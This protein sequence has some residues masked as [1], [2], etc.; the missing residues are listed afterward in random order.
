MGPDHEKSIL[1]TLVGCA[2][3]IVILMLASCSGINTPT[4][5]LTPLPGTGTPSVTQEPNSCKPM[6][7]ATSNGIALLNLPDGSQVFLA[8]NTE[9]DFVPAGNCP[10][11]SA[12]QLSLIK[13]EIAVRSITPNE[14]LFKIITPEGYLVTL[15][16]TGLIT[17]DLEKHRVTV[18]CSN[19]FCTLGTADKPV[20]I[21][22]GQM[23]EMD[24]GPVINGPFAID[25]SKLAPYGEWLMPKCGQGSTATPAVSTPTP[26]IGATATAICSDWKNQFPMTP[27][28]TMTNP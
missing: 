12:H 23:A 20:M 15:N 1:R 19:G 26:D 16:D 21:T 25:T 13:G 22:C 10:G 24:P 7:V 28:P 6:R 14:Q 3:L 18:N 11:E 27:C 4:Q 17:Y 5:V 8:A 9:F 2:G